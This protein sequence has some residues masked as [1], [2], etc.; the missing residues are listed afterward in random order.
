MRFKESGDP[1]IWYVNQPVYSLY[2]RGAQYI[3]HLIR[4]NNNQYNIDFSNHS[5][6]P[7]CS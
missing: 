2:I 7:S 4:S 6:S 1:S 3:M 5:Q